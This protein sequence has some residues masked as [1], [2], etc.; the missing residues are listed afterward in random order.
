VV[1]MRRG[2]KLLDATDGGDDAARSGVSAA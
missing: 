2:W 1:M